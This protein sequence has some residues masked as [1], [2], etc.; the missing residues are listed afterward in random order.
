MMSRTT[1]NPFRA[2]SDKHWKKFGKS[3]PYFGVLSDEKFK[4][5]VLDDDARAEFFE[6]GR[7]EVTKTLNRFRSEFGDFN[8]G[9][10]LDFGCGVGR[11]TVHLA[12]HF[13]M[14]TAIDISPDM[15]G[16]A[17]RNLLRYDRHNVVLR[18]AIG[19]GVFDFVYSNI[20]LQHIN[21]TTGLRILDA[22]LCQVNSGGGGMIQLIFR[23]PEKFEK[24][25][26][27]MDAAPWLWGFRN[28]RKGRKF[29]HP[30]MATYAYPID[31][32]LA[33]FHEA[34]IASLFSEFTNHNDH[35][36][37]KIFFRKPG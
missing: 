31:E 3:N 9:S 4:S 28:L 35:I 15:L 23:I 36:G 11:N 22:M 12:S 24:L 10:C 37:L 25:N 8:Q 19:G 27:R 14:V 34:G 21:P 13:E 32:V 7:I 30:R 6:T 17:R 16:E 1:A 5:D 18:E 2:R 20:V 29:S 33:L 26:R